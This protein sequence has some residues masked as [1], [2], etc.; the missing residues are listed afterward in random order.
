MLGLGIVFGTNAQE[1]SSFWDSI[2]NPTTREQ[3]KSFVAAKEA[4][5]YAAAKTDG[6]GMP[7]EYKTLF[8][9]ADK[10][11]WLTVSNLFEEIGYHNGGLQEES[12]NVDTT[13][14]GIR[15]EA[16]K[17]TWGACAAYAEGNEKYSDLIGN[18]I[19]QSIPPGSIYFGGTDPGR[20]IVTALQKSQ[21][22]GEPFFTL[23]QNA[24]VDGS[25]LDYLRSMYGKEIYI[26]T[27]DDCQKCFNDYYSDV[28]KRFENHQLKPGEDVTIASNGQL[29]VSGQIAVMGV[30]A[31]LVKVIFDHETNLEFYVEESVPLEWMYP[32]LEPH[33]LIFKLN[34]EPLAQIP[35]DV[36]QRDND[37]WARMISPMIGDWLHDDTPVTNVTAFAEKIFLQHDFDGFAGD[38]NFV[39]R[40]HPNGIF[41]KERAEIAGLYVWRAK[42]A[43]DA[44]EKERMNREADFAFRQAWALRPNSPEAVFL[45]VQFLMDSLRTDDAIL[46]TQTCV[47]LNPKN[48]SVVSLLNNLERYKKQSEKPSK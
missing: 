31:L 45:Y 4:Q 33:G 1:N 6:K 37:Y 13:F 18:E 39:K 7:P 25:Y 27:P 24:L 40:I 15:W 46:I 21:I 23:T 44:Q 42:H 29:Q 43:H 28:Q 10:G 22:K 9:A 30:N 20:F 12:T 48:D 17:E 8:N 3:L 32:Y 16:L 35:D 36:V 38:P 14:R 26:P 34:R 2:K 41:S 5:A 11:D 47:K 19:I